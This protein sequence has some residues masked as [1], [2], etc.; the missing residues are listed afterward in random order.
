MEACRQALIQLHA[1]GQHAPHANPLFE[2]FARLLSYE[3]IHSIYE[4]IRSAYSNTEKREKIAEALH[5]ATRALADVYEIIPAH[6]I[7][8]WQATLKRLDNTGLDKNINTFAKEYLHTVPHEAYGALKQKIQT[9]LEACR[10][11]LEDIKEA[12]RVTPS[13]LFEFFTRVLKNG[14]STLF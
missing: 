11:S 12:Q 2:P 9:S 6:C 4:G 5:G 1:E 13:P 8:V 7:D 10:Q 14:R 3:G